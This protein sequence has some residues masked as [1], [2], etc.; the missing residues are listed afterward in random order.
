MLSSTK[1]FFMDNI[2][3]V[4]LP[5]MSKSNQSRE[6]PSEPAQQQHAPHSLAQ[7]T[8]LA[9]HSDVSSQNSQAM[10]EDDMTSEQQSFYSAR[11]QDESNTSLLSYT[12]HAVDKSKI[13]ENN[14]RLNIFLSLSLIAANFCLIALEWFSYDAHIS[15][16]GLDAL[17]SRGQTMQLYVSVFAVRIEPSGASLS[18]P[19]FLDQCSELTKRRSEL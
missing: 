1:N 15:P 3:R 4:R 12:Q 16:N 10:G 17:S 9:T 11:D 18:M 13:G 8:P 5:G 6:A 19:D 14:L 2:S 7:T